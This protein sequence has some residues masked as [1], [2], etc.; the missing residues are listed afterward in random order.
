MLDD[1]DEHVRA[2]G[3]RL[4]T[5][6]LPLDLATGAPR[7]GGRRGLQVVSSRRSAGRAVF[8][9]HCGTCHRLF[10]AGGAI[11]PD[12][13]GGDRRNLDYL[14]SNIVDPSAVVTKNFLVTRSVLVG[15]RGI[16]GIVVGENEATVTVQTPQDRQTI[17]VGDIESREN[18]TVSLMPD[19]L[20]LPLGEQ[21]IVDL[22]AS[23][24]ADAQ[25]QEAETRRD[26]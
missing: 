7:A 19:A 9:R 1:A 12:L 23:I 13:T 22:V 3:V 11:G 24:R 17:S 2:W 26:R 18:S 15:G 25:P 20:L 4:L 14:L 16:G 6:D 10:G 21:E 8:A 5:D